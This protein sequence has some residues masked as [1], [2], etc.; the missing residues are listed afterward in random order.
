M[1]LSRVARAVPEILYFRCPNCSKRFPGSTFADD[2]LYVE[3]H[4]CGSEVESPHAAL[5]S[6][7]RE[8]AS[9]FS[10]AGA[11][12]IETPSGVAAQTDDI[13][14]QLRETFETLSQMD[15]ERFLEE[16]SPAAEASP[17]A[18][19]PVPSMP[20]SR[21]THVIAIVVLLVIGALLLG[22]LYMETLPTEMSF[23]V[24]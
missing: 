4:H 22:M 13:T 24:K 12:G 21:A 9:P 7:R 20:F 15:K 16:T 2:S 23:S 6:S 3:C 18:V 10:I 17:E 19:V 8:E 14:A 1:L 11:S 5:A